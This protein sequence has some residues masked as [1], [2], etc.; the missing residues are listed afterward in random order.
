MLRFVVLVV[1]NQSPVIAI[2]KDMTS[3][4]VHERCQKSPIDCSLLSSTSATN[5]VLPCNCLNSYT[6]NVRL[7]RPPSSD[8]ELFMC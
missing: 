6:Q 4:L 8:V 2:I 1:F 3:V 5:G 7:L